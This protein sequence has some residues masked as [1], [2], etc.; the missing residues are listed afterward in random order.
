VHDLALGQ[1]PRQLAIMLASLFAASL[2]A[3]GAAGAPPLLNLG[4][5]LVNIADILN[6]AG[7]GAPAGIAR[8]FFPIAR[9]CCSALPAGVAPALAGGVLAATLVWLDGGQNANRGG[10]Q[11][12]GSPI[13]WVPDP[14]SLRHGGVIGASSPS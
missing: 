4:Y 14:V 2:A 11:L 8:V 12:V 6:G 10:A 9:V 7:G 1:T 13:C 3:N 5:S